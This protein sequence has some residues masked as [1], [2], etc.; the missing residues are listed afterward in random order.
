MHDSFRVTYEVEQVQ[1]DLPTDIVHVFVEYVLVGTVTIFSG[2]RSLKISPC[3]LLQV[4]QSLVRLCT[5][6]VM[7]GVEASESRFDNGA[8]FR[9]T[10]DDGVLVLEVNPGFKEHNLVVRVPPVEAQ[11]IVGSF[12]RDVLLDLF[13][14]CPK[15]QYENLLLLKIRDAFP[16]AGLKFAGKIGSG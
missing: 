7:Y 11:K 13:R 6:P 16:L 12:H 8:D 2:E 15:L 14:L 9:S 5:F 10:F 1:C 4:S 3:G